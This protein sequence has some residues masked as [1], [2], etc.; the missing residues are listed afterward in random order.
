MSD[1]AYNRKLA[2]FKSRMRSTVNITYSLMTQNPMYPDDPTKQIPA[3]SPV[4]EEFKIQ[5]VRSKSTKEE[6]SE[7]GAGFI[8]DTFKWILSLKPIP[9][10]SV[11][12]FH[13]VPY[14]VGKLEHL[15]YRDKIY[16]YRSPVG[17]KNS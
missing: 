9:E 11:F 3:G 1:P 16:G 2:T 4:T 15:V 10:N 14:F 6:Y 5:L 12:D 17:V 13:G 8:P 7:G